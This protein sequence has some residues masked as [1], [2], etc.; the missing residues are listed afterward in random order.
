M[1]KLYLT[2]SSTSS[3]HDYP[4]I[5]TKSPK[6]ELSADLKH[7]NAYFYGEAL[8]LTNKFE[9]P[10]FLEGDMAQ[11][12]LPVQEQ[13]IY[14]LLPSGMYRVKAESNDFHNA[15]FGGSYLITLMEEEHDSDNNY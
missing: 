7:G 3:E 2:A 12:T 15:E 1:N 8:N 5:K 9:T 6:V 11:L 14:L 10:F 13:E 4:L